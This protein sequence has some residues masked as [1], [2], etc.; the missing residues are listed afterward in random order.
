LFINLNGTERTRN[1]IMS[2]EPHQPFQ[3]RSVLGVQIAVSSYD[4]V[5]RT[6]LLWAQEGESRA[7]FFAAVHMVMEAVDHPEFLP[8]LNSAGTVFPDGMPLVWALKALGEKNARRVCGT[9]TT[10]AVLAA[11][12]KSCF[13]VGFYGGSPATL[14]ALVATVRV[15]HPNLNIAYQESPPF[16]P[17][18]AVEDAAIVD[19]ITASGARLLFVGLGC[20]KQERWIVDHLG[21]VPAVMF[22]VGAA[23]DFIAGNK[24]RGPQWMSRNGLEWVYRLVSEP[25]RLAMRYLKH[26][27]R[28]LLLFLQQLLTRSA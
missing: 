13:S 3:T 8:V 10:S 26:N 2:A 19:R 18:T 6:S 11:A 7:F 12:E 25:R 14:D 21:R 9:D 17:L 28:F 5:I 20:P 24:S 4:E 22:A 1:L 23:F 27:P 16:R 15:L